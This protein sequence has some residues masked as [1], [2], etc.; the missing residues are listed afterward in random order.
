MEIS[1]PMLERTVIAYSTEGGAIVCADEM[2]A[3]SLTCSDVYGN[4]GGDWTGCIADQLG[5]NGNF[6]ADPKFC[7]AA[8]ADFTLEDCSPCVPGNHPGDYDC[9]GAIGSFESACGCGAPT[10]PATWGMIKSMYR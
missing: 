5:T 2:S 10:E 4:T 7:D 6:S 3:A 9:G 8:G 1:T